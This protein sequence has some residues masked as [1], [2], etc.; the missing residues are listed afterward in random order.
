MEDLEDLHDVKL[1][2]EAQNYEAKALPFDEA[3]QI[4]NEKK[5]NRKVHFNL[6]ILRK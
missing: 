6:Q 5:G 4:M 2:D 1:F 3:F